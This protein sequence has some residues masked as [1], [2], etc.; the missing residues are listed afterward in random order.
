MKILIL[1]GFGY[2]G[3][4][5]GQYLLDNTT[6]EVSGYDIGWYPL[7][8]LNRF[9]S[10]IMA[11]DYRYLTVNSLR[12]FDVIILLASHPSVASCKGNFQSAFNNNVRNFAELIGK[13]NEK[14]VFIYAS[15]ASVYGSSP[16]ISDESVPLSRSLNEYDALKKTIDELAPF[17]RAQ[18]YGLRFGTVNG[19]SLN[20]RTELMINSMYLSALNTGYI[21]V[22]NIHQY[23]AILGINDLCSAITAIIDQRN[24]CRPRG[25]YNLASFNDYIGRIAS[26]VAMLTYPAGIHYIPDTPTYSFQI[27][28][29]KFE[30][31]FR[32]R[33]HDDVLSIVE[34]LQ[35]I[36]I[37]PKDY[38]RNFAREY[39]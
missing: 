1:G 32:W 5:L 17:C 27:D 26:K 36:D 7:K 31:T 13:L 30:H 18:W 15:S 38:N 12:L 11:G 22:N 25:I 16:G 39:K 20:I 34:S 9:H 29:S 4:T 35:G 10:T 2:I 6:H 23:R 14:H 28:C 8:K 3:S 19:F 33:P 24:E 37:E 21:K